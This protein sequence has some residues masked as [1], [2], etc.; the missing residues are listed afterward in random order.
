M[1]Y[2]SLRGMSL[3]SR[4]MEKDTGIQ[5]AP[6]SMVRFDCPDGHQTILPMSDDADLPA[7]WECRCGKTAL[8]QNATM[9]EPKKPKRSPRTH[10]D[11]L[12]ERRTR[13]D[14]EELLT[15]RLQLL[16]SGQLRRSV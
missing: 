14:L 5:F 2:R 8:R 16:R 9:P 11:M 15:E 6:R 4:S 12:L 3:G 10:W 13:D 7:I 1:A